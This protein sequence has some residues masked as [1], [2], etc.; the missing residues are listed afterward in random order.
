VARCR[1]LGIEAYLT[2]PVSRDELH[3]AILKALAG[4]SRFPQAGDAGPGAAPRKSVSR[5]KGPLRI[6]LAEDNMVNQKVVVHFLEKEGHTVQIAAN[7]REAV[8]ALER[9]RFDLVLMDVQMPEMDGFEATAAI[10]ARERFTGARLPILAMTAHAMSGDRERCLAAGMDGYVA[11][12]VHKAELLEAIGR[13]SA[14]AGS[15][16]RANWNVLG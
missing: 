13:V 9:E 15:W 1:E 7:G 16:D 8:S 3:A 4:A 5:P 12:P 2:K 11:K 14:E 6:L 10:R